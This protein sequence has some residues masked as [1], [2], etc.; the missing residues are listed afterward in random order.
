MYRELVALVVAFS[1]GWAVNGWRKDA[2][3]NQLIAAQTQ[4]ALVA[5]TKARKTEQDLL[6]Q[7]QQTKDKKDAE[8]KTIN[9][10]LSAALRGLRNRPKRSEVPTVTATGSTQS[11]TGAE[12]YR[13]DAE[14]LIREAARADETLAQLV[15]CQAQYNAARTELNKE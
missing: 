13:Q 6:V 12:L 1:M 8:L 2:E 7:V 9:A 4:A 15:Q 10:K 3:I 5:E 11:C 14:F